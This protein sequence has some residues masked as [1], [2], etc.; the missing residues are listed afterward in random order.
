MLQTTST[1]QAV[2]QSQCGSAASSAYKASDAGSCR[3]LSAH[4]HQL[5]AAPMEHTLSFGA[6]ETE[7][8]NQAW[9]QCGFDMQFS[10]DMRKRNEMRNSASYF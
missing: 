8:A 1:R 3:H 10:K 5:S 2:A 6:A 9:V 4:L 7:P